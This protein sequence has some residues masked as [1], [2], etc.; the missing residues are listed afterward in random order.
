MLS[1]WLPHAKWILI[2]NYNFKND[3]THETCL[4]V[5]ELIYG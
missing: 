5:V 1:C 2:K 3:N 4:L